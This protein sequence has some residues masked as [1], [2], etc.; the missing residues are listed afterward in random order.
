ML[1][2]VE[3]QATG[4]QITV[5]RVDEDFLGPEDFWVFDGDAPDD[6][7]AI[8]MHYDADGSPVEF[9]H[10]TDPGQ[11]RTMLEQAADLEAEDQQALNE[12]LASRGEVTGAA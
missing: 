10:V 11:V 1:A 2:Y 9:E 4:E 3:S 8:W 7:Y 5:L 6:R 12:H